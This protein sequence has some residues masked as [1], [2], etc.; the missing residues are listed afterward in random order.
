MLKK[1]RDPFEAIAELEKELGLPN[2]FYL[3]LEKDDDWS[4]VIKLHA[5][6]E[7][8]IS[9][10]LV[11]VLGYQELLEVISQ[12]EMSN[13]TTGKIALVKALGLLDSEYRTFI[14]K[15]SEIRNKFVHDVS[16]VGITLQE[17]VNRP[18]QLDAL[19][20]AFSLGIEKIEFD[21][22]K[23]EN[24]EYM[25]ED[26]KHFIWLAG[27]TCLGV[28]YMKKLNQV[29]LRRLKDIKEHKLGELDGAIQILTKLGIYTEA[30]DK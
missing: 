13:N 9:G 29:D 10:L 23:L 16:N 20:K 19:T 26:P 11:E 17:Y 30:E 18:G 4:F 2:D 15:L 7:A 28:I 1:P 14:R 5:L 3:N 25:A 27:A 12:L 8:A 24:K 22:R 21:E 6:L